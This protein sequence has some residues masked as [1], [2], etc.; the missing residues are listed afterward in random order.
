[1]AVY[2][3]QKHR[4]KYAGLWDKTKTYNPYS[5]VTT[6]QGYFLSASPVPAGIDISN[7]SYWIWYAGAGDP[8][9]LEARV[10]ALEELTTDMGSTIAIQGE[11]LDTIS[12]NVIEQGNQIIELSSALS[13]TGEA[14]QALDTRL[15]T[16]EGQI[17]NLASALSV[18]GRRITDL[19]SRVTVNENNIRSLAS[20]FDIVGND[21]DHINTDAINFV[22]MITGIN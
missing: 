21:V 20:T 3:D 22:R 16:S 5:I 17:T 6:D 18:T 9:A 15:T 8:S 1:M 14:L 2:I 10:T 13:V 11:L 7:D 12:D 19:E 4:A